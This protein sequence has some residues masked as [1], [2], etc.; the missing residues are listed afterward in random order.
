MLLTSD[1]TSRAAPA[2]GISL[3]QKQQVTRDLL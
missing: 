1:P 3:E 2:D